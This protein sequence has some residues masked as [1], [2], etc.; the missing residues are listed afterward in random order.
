MLKHQGSLSEAADLIGITNYNVVN[1]E[2]A[3]FS[4]D[5]GFH[6]LFNVNLGTTRL[7]FEYFENRCFYLA[8]WHHMESLGRRG[9]WRTCLEFN[10]LLFAYAF[11]SPI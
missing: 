4:L 3:L 11:V 2:R 1:I 10:K 7:P 5:C 8:L 9:C 6:P